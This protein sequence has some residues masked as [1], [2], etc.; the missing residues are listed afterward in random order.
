VKRSSAVLAGGVV[1]AVVTEVCTVGLLG[2]SG[3]FIASS[4]VAGA[5]LASTF[6]YFAPSGGVRAFAVGR[7]ASGYADRV[8]LHSAALD[9]VAAARVRFYDAAATSGSD[10]TWSGQSLDRVMADAD[11]S[12]MALIRATAPMVVAA[13][14]IPLGILVIALAG[15]AAAALLVAIAAAASAALA[16]ASARGTHDLSPERIALRTELVTAVDA[17]PE[18][19]SLGVADE[20]ARRT[21]DRL[22]AF[23]DEQARDAHRQSTTVAVARAVTASALALAVA[24]SARAGADAPT[25]VLIA[26]LTTGAMGNAERIV[27]AAHGR[28]AARDA[29]ARLESVDVSDAL[30]LPVEA[31]YDGNRLVV[32]GYELPATPT[33]AGRTVSLTAE[34]GDTVVVTGTSGSGKTTLMHAIEWELRTSTLH[35]SNRGVVTSVLADDYVFTGSIASNIRLAAPAA[36]D[37]EV[38]ALLSAMLLDRGGLEPNTAVGVGGRELSGGEQRRLAIARALATTPDVLLVDEPT[39]ALDDATADHVLAAIRQRLPRAVVVYAMHE[40]PAQTQSL[41]PMFLPLSLDRPPSTLPGDG[42]CI[43]EL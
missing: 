8:T 25:L 27:G 3:W 31:T 14:V 7:I 9:R 4:A 39:T 1:L 13:A 23:E 43:R 36:T 2:L 37:A 10:A 28:V 20:L 42:R 41:G 33:R 38:W 5:S 26:L 12:G 16:F 30:A 40:L 22:D 19:A 17:W 32:S 21:L 15:Y 24:V 6:S 18:M 34:A 29:D 35:P 11:N